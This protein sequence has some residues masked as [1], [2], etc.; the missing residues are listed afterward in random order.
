MQ[1]IAAFFDV[2]NSAQLG[3]AH[4]VNTQARLTAALADAEVHV[5]E[6][7]VHFAPQ[8]AIPHVGDTAKDADLDLPSFLTQ[9]S[10]A[11][12]AVKLDIHTA[13][14][15]EPSLAILRL[16]K[17]ATPV[18]L[19]ADIFALLPTTATQEGLEPEQFIRLC[20]TACP[21]AVL[22]LG[23]SLKRSHDADGRVED[24]LI[25]QMTSMILQRLGPV[26]YG[27]EIR[28]G[29]TTGPHGSNAERGAAV[30]LDPLPGQP[31]PMGNRMAGPNVVD[32][33]PHLRNVA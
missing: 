24:A 1:S 9:A 20:Q 32:L 12:K 7:D 3:W 21:K 15:V 31:S 10:L 25:Q 22:S 18:I 13:A 4:R 5:V 27:V 11:N 30:I 23:W 29:Y 17:P 26:S 8:D 28:A 14:A 16:M 6:A 33:I 2:E 19:H